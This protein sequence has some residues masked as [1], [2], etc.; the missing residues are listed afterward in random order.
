MIKRSGAWVHAPLLL[1]KS[2]LFDVLCFC[3]IVQ[4]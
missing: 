3:Y 4:F 2:L 1:Q